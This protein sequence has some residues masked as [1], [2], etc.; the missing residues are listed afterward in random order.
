MSG[1]EPMP[2]RIYVTLID[3][4]AAKLLAEKQPG[5]LDTEYVRADLYENNPSGGVD[6]IGTITKLQA[7]RDRYLG[8]RDELR[9][10]QKAARPMLT[11]SNERLADSALAAGAS[12]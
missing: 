12:E 4:E 5:D 6:L 7:Q 1:P 9:R 11:L 3:A 10:W 8:E 2:D